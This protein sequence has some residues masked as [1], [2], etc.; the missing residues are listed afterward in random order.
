MI[1]IDGTICTE[2]FDNDGKKNYSKATP[3]KNRI[4]Y[5]NE[6]YDQGNEIHYWT[7][8][9]SVTA[10]RDPANPAYIPEITK[11]VSM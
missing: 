6:L 1:D 9:G 8:R 4:K 2:H 11:A 7:A 5:L 3:I 10:I